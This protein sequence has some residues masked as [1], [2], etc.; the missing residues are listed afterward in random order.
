MGNAM[1]MPDEQSAHLVRVRFG[2]GASYHEFLAAIDEPLSDIV[3]AD[4]YEEAIVSWFGTNLEEITLLQYMLQRD[5]DVP[6]AFARPVLNLVLRKP[7]GDADRRVAA[8]R[9][10]ARREEL[11][12][13]YPLPQASLRPARNEAKARVMSQAEELQPP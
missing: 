6:M 8:T 12:L 7:S 13:A 5:L 11:A 10:A 3:I 4:G 2:L 1:G 9:N